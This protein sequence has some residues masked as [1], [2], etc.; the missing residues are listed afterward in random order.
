[1]YADEKGAMAE[2]NLTISEEKEAAIAL[3]E[4]GAIYVGSIQQEATGH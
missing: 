1:M 3:E 2:E 4:A